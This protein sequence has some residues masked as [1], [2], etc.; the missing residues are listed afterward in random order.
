MGKR[1]EA[2]QHHEELTAFRLF[3]I[4]AGWEVR[5]ENIHQGIPDIT[6]TLVD[7]S[8][9][10]LELVSLD[11]GHTLR[12]M[13]NFKLTQP[14]WER[15]IAGL[16][17]AK[18]Q[19][20]RERYSNASLGLHFVREPDRKEM[21]TIFPEI[22][23]RLFDLPADHVGPIFPLDGRHPWV[24]WSRLSRGGYSGGPFIVAVSASRP[25]KPDWN[26]IKDKLMTKG[27]RFGDEVELLAY[28]RYD[29]LLPSIEDAVPT[30]QIQEWLQGSTFSRV[31]VLD[32]FMR[33][34]EA[35][36]TRQ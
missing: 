23:D 19:S 33:T 30:V 36:I 16:P 20:V 15:A 5:A 18:N 10:Q 24:A 7:G 6:C 3:S 35:L 8:L 11:A 1:Q 29:T 14:M 34:I 2:D 9:R 31:W 32:G 4:V 12:R 26:R 21:K 25:F 27:Y 17:S 22:I 28:S 13:S